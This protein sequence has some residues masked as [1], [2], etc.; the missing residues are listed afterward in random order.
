MSFYLSVDQFLNFSRSVFNFQGDQFLNFSR[1]FFK[2]QSPSVLT[3]QVDQFLN[4]SRSV[5]KFQVDQFLL[6]SLS[7]FFKFQSISFLRKLSPGQWRRSFEG[8]A[9]IPGTNVIKLFFLRHWW[10]N[11]LAYFDPPLEVSKQNGLHSGRLRPSSKERQT[12]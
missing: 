5:L 9:S 8:S 1:S 12:L 2:F 3:L 10:K 11:T 6:F 4:F 7:V